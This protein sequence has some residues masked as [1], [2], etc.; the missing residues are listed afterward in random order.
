NLVP[1]VARGER[2][3]DVQSLAA[4]R[5]HERLEAEVGEAF[6]YEVG[7]GHHVAPGDGGIRVEVEHHAIGLVEVAHGRA[8]H[9]QLDHAALH[10]ADHRPRAVGDR[11][12]A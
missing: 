11:V 10:E 1:F 12:D 7:G 2:H 3:H 9:V 5:L 8:P 4:A 6:A